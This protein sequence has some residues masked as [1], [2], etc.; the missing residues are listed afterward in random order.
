MD[1]KILIG[2]VVAII[3]LIAGYFIFFNQSTSIDISSKPKT[4]SGDVSNLVLPLESFPEGYKIVER[5]PRTQSDVSD[6][7]LS[8]G[9]IEGYNIRY[10]K[11]DE[12]NLLDVS[13]I[14]LSISRYPLENVSKG[15]EKGAYEFEGY[16]AE[17]LPNP[18]IGEGSFVT[19]YT[20]EVWGLRDYQIEFYKK[21]IFVTLTNGGSSTDYEFLKELAKEVESKI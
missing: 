10:L 5:T 17:E 15:I 21:D 2:S 19:R 13:R 7:G 11:G 4:Y 9:W 14:E 3:I 16:L 8:V 18:Q 6:F 1:K 20:D 12:E